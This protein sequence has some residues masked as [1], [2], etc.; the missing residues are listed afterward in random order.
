MI[1][2]DT[3]LSIFTVHPI[4]GASPLYY[5]ALCGFQDLVEDLVIK[6]PQDVNASSGCYVTPLVAALAGGHSQTA[7]YFY[8]NGARLNIPGGSQRNSLH[9]VAWYGDFEMVQ[10]LID[11]KADI[12]ARSC[13]KRTPLQEAS[14][15]RFSSEY[16]P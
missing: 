7:K 3:S 2:F 6:Y 10:T 16:I 13:D 11:Y 14:E 5:A 4:S 1:D 12:N 8:D 15:G 9:S